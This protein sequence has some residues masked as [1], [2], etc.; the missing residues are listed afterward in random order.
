MSKKKK[1]ISKILYG[2]FP[3]DGEGDTLRQLS[4]RTVQP[5]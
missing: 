3:T 1:K 5:F 4:D 2:S